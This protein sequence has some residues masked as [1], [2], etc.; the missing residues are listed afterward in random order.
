MSKLLDFTSLKDLLARGNGKKKVRGCGYVERKV[1]ISSLLLQ[2]AAA[3]ELISSIIEEETSKVARRLVG[4]VS[5]YK[6]LLQS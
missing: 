6:V 5:F 4:G 3:E 2:N 1:L